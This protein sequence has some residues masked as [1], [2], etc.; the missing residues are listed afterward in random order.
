MTLKDETIRKFEMSEDPA[1]SAID[2]MISKAIVLD[3]LFDAFETLGLEEGL[4]F[5]NKPVTDIE[6]IQRPPSVVYVN[7]SEKLR[8]VCQADG[9]PTPTY[10]YYKDDVSVAMG[11][12][13]MKDVASSCDSGQ[14]KCLIKQRRGVDVIVKELTFKVVV[15]SGI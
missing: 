5:L 15:K 1:S 13:F 6:I 8:V 14:Y 4:L 3:E 2:Y 7:S 10:E 11:A 12:E 9:F